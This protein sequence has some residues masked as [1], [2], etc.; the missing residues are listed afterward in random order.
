MSVQPIKPADGRAAD[1]LREASLLAVTHHLGETESDIDPRDGWPAYAADWRD[2]AARAADMSLSP[3]SWAKAAAIAAERFPD[4]AAAFSILA[5]N[6]A[7]HLPTPASFARIAVAGLGMDYDTALGAALG[8]A[9]DAEPD[10]QTTLETPFQHAARAEGGRC[11]ELAPPPGSCLPLAQWGLRLTPAGLARAFAVSSRPQGTRIAATHSPV[12]A[13]A[14]QTAARI[15]AADGVVWLRSGSQRMARQLAADLAALTPA[16]AFDLVDLRPGE[17]I[18]LPAPDSL[19]SAPLV[20]DLFALDTPPRIPPCPSGSSGLVLLAP[21]RFEAGHLR[22]VDAPA[23]TPAE[24][25]AAWQAAGIAPDI[26]DALAPRFQLTLAELLAARQETE[27]RDSLCDGTPGDPTDGF[28]AAIRAAGARRMGPFVTHVHSAT[29]LDDLVASQSILTQL[30]DAIAWRRA[31][32]RV[33][34]DMGLPRDAGESQ[35]LSLLFS[36]PPGGGKTF[37]ARCLAN[38]LGLNLYRTDLSQVVSKYIGETEKNLS[39]IFDDAEA[40]HGI[41]FFDEADAV[42]GKRSEVKDAHD[43]YANIEVGFLLQRLETFAGIVILATNLRANLDPAFM[44]RM[45]FI[46]DFPM[47]QQAERERLWRRNLPLPEWCDDG[48]DIAMLAER[49]RFA[50]GN[51]RNAAVAAAHLAAAEGARLGPRHLARA[52]VR[53]LEKSGLPRGVDDLGP[54]A[55]WLEDAR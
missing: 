42:F 49:F 11:V 53:E 45:Q 24:A 32:A 28:A 7:L 17:T 10:I 27:T 30:R 34:T 29:R 51:I 25:R 48:L 9:L 19:Q 5:D 31:Q 20:V 39:R 21:E 55:E 2:L 26:A 47:P 35:G 13:R 23:F 15:L 52:V 6:P 43:R 46:I 41:L 33:W 54:L 8:V 38:A 16:R 40:G 36:G 14:A 37:A 50:G 4:A 22:A 3:A 1:W 44:R 18:P 12:L